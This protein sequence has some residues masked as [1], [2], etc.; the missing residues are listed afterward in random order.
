MSITGPKLLTDGL[1]NLGT[2]YSEKPKR[3]SV[4][5]VFLNIFRPPARK[6][7]NLIQKTSKLLLAIQLNHQTSK[8]T[9][10]YSYYWNKI[11]PKEE[12]EEN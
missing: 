7:A 1:A 4:E 5:I 2:Q 3:T 11:L 6:F 8:Q 12:D 9:K 10:L